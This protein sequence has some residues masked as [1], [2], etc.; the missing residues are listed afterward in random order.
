MATLTVRIDDSLEEKLNELARELGRSRS[1]IV[2]DLLRR[3]LAVEAIEQIRR[4]VMPYAEA[5]GYLTD[6][7]VFRDIS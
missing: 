5:A 2:R 6:E 1:D 7:D 3:H 4:E